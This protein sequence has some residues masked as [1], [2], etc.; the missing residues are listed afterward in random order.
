[1][2]TLRNTTYITT[3]FLKKLF[4]KDNKTSIN[5]DKTVSSIMTKKQVKMI[6]QH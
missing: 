1:M 2:D 3:S 6:L 4:N 5:F